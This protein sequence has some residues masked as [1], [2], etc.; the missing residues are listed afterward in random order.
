MPSVTRIN[1]QITPTIKIAIINSTTLNDFCKSEDIPMNGC[2]NRPKRR[3]FIFRYTQPH[4]YQPTSLEYSH[5][6]RKWK[7]EFQCTFCKAKTREYLVEDT[8]LMQIFNLKV[9]PKPGKY[10]GGKMREVLGIS[11][12][13]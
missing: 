4:D 7:I 13:L 9:A 8:K 5:F 3:F 2:P 6:F 11:D 12:T 10:H 1:P